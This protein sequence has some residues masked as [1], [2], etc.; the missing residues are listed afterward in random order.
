MKKQVFNPFLPLDRCV[1]DNEAHV[2]EDR[3]YIY[4]SHDKEGGDAFC[5]LGYEVWSAPINDLTDWRNEGTIYTPEQDPDF[6][7]TYRCLYAPDVVRGNDGRYYLY[8]A[9]SGGGTFTGNFHVAVCDFPAGRFE[10]YGVVT[11]ADGMPFNDNVTFDPGVINDGGTIRLYYGWSLSVEKNKLKGL[12]KN[13][14]ISV[15]MNLFAKTREAVTA[16]P[17]GVMGA[18]TVELDDDM[19]TVK[20]PTKHIVPGQFSAQGTSFEGHA[21]Y[22]ASSIRKIGDT[23]YFVY[24]SEHEHELCYCTSKSP[25][26]DFVFGGVIISN[27]DIGYNGRAECDRLAATGNNHGSIEKIGNEWYVFYH[28]QTHNTSFSRQGCAE[29]ITIENGKIGQV[30]MTSC[31]LN[32]APLATEGKYS[33]AIACNLTRGEMPHVSPVKNAEDIPYIT[34]ADNEHFITGI[35]DG[36]RIGYKYFKFNGRT[37]LKIK[38]DGEGQGVFK[39][40]LNEKRIAEIKVFADKPTREYSVAFEYGGVCALYFEYYGEGKRNLYSFSFD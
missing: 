6:G 4:G 9:M 32:G 13:K 23:Y 2:F 34:N 28:R 7:E 24:S 16:F 5:M 33:A 40:Y 39:V 26:K 15:Q 19:L 1:C 14:L 11:R 12:D 31:G 22:E 38:T 25:D 3:V 35:S 17:Y 21:F 10:Y 27:G 18:F 8:Y 36:T 30:E 37:E 29:R 20:S